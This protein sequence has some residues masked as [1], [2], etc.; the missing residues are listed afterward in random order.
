VFVS[1][2]GCM[3]EGSFLGLRGWCFCRFVLESCLFWRVCSGGLQAE[4][5]LGREAGAFYGS[6]GGWCLGEAEV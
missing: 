4:L 6:R 5:Q 2:R 1:S 3:G